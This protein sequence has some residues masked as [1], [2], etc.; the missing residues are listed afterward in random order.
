MR[1]Y[2]DSAS[3]SEGVPSRLPEFTAEESEEI[4]GEYNDFELYH[5][6]NHN[7]YMLVSN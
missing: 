1:Q 6:Y 4:K 5:N 2:V 3:N 7:H